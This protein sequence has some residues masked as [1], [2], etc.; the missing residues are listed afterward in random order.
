VDSYDGD[1]VKFCGDAILIMWSTNVNANAS[2]KKAVTMKAALCALHLIDECGAYRKIIHSSKNKNNFAS[3]TANNGDILHSISNLFTE[4]LISPSSR[5]ASPKNNSRSSFLG[6]RRSSTAGAAA[7]QHQRPSVIGNISHSITVPNIQASSKNDH[8]YQP[9]DMFEIELSLHCGVACG[10]V[11]C[12]IIGDPSSRHEFFLSGNVLKD[13]SLAESSSKVNQVC[14]HSSC[15]YYLKK[16]FLLKRVGSEEIPFVAP[17][18]SD[19]THQ[20][21]LT[22]LME[23]RTGADDVHSF[24]LSAISDG[25]PDM[26]EEEKKKTNMEAAKQILLEESEEGD[27]QSDEVFL[28]TGL[29]SEE[30]MD[31]LVLNNITLPVI[32]PIVSSLSPR[33]DHRNRRVS[34]QQSNDNGDPYDDCGKQTGDDELDDDNEDEECEEERKEDVEVNHRSSFLLPSAIIANRNK[35]KQIKK[36]GRRKGKIN[37]SFASTV[38]D[39]SSRMVN[40]LY[41]MKSSFLFPTNSSFLLLNSSQSAEESHKIGLADIIPISLQGSFLNRTSSANNNGI[42]LKI[43]SSQLIDQLQQE[44]QQQQAKSSKYSI[45]EIKE[46]LWKSNDPTLSKLFHSATITLSPSNEITENDLTEQQLHCLKV[47]MRS[48]IHE[49]VLKSIDCN[50]CALLSEMRDIVTLFINLDGL[51]ADFNSGMIYKPQLVFLTIMNLI[52]KTGGSLRQFVVDDKGCVVI[53]CFGLYGSSNANNGIQ[54]ITLCLLLKK[55]LS[56]LQ[57]RLSIGITSGVVYCGNVGSEK[58]CEFVVMGNSVNL[59][60]RLMAS[61]NNNNAFLYLDTE[62][63]NLSMIK[64]EFQQTQSIQA[65][66]YDYPI[67]VYTLI[68]NFLLRRNGFSV[69]DEEGEVCY[70]GGTMVGGDGVDTRNN[71]CSSAVVEQSKGLTNGKDKKIQFYFSQEIEKQLIEITEMILHPEL[72]IHQSQQPSP[73]VEL[74]PGMTASSVAT[75]FGNNA[76]TLF[77]SISI[78]GDES[79]GKTTFL[80]RLARNIDSTN[81]KSHQCLLVK[82][83]NPFLQH[84]HHQHK[85][86]VTEAYFGFKRILSG[87]LSLFLIKAEEREEEGESTVT[88]ELKRRSIDFLLKRLTEDD[89]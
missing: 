10:K 44:Q 24:H 37:A 76:S 52:K 19:Q 25:K 7:V 53:V 84:H 89:L 70:T 31:Y 51:E 58:R 78:V 30:F 49:T 11:N 46:I 60:A 47:L 50:T 45:H 17:S 88:K 82:L 26:S 62:V 39:L 42:S 21:A 61:A 41:D 54:A 57:C 73:V 3:S 43:P 32:A 79:S 59:A 83:A 5:C 74:K 34:F 27:N 14:I 40:S 71:T 77:G 48:F 35:N 8:T 64:Y 22:T 28:F 87:F 2:N 13:L 23:G 36:K 4:S 15:F 20:S 75:A 1:V 56:K 80:Q 66:G 68:N 67:A 33:H 38:S 85:G 69:G 86:D 16:Y 63:R 81:N 55:E 18:K 29:F 72:L 9:Q 65:K 12:M 6:R